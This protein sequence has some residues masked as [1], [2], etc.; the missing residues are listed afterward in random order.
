MKTSRKGTWLQAFM[1]FTVPLLMLGFFRWALFEPFVIPSGSMIPNLLIHD[2]L[3]VKKFSYGLKVPFV[4]IWI[5]RWAEPRAGQIVV[6]K[7]PLKTSVYYVKRLIGGPGDHILFK[8]GQLTV[9]GRPWTLTP[10]EPPV[11]FDDLFDYFREDSGQE[12]HVVR[13]RSGDLKSREAFEVTLKENEYFMMGDNRDE[14]L[15]SRYWGTVE[16][17]FLVAP[18][19]KVLLGC[20]ETLASNSMLC[21]PATL[22]PERFWQD[23]NL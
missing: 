20:R 6:F 22:K 14:S 18:A 15:D 3:V 11:G 7:Y 13:Y 4:D 1:A 8:N 23:V 9:N 17:R 5:V 10:I 21:N 16:A 12:S 2:H 19:W